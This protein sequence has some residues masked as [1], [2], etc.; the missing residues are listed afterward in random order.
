MITVARDG[1]RFDV[2]YNDTIVL[3]QKT[4]FMPISNVSNSNFSGITSGS[5]G[6]VGQLALANVYNYRLSSQDVVLKYREFSDT[7]GRP[8]INSTANPVAL[9]DTAG[10]NPGFL[11]GLTLSSFIPS[12]SALTLCPAGGCFSPPT[13]RPASPLYEWSTSYA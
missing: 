3:S 9:A 5:S 10:L 2:Y 11:S 1:R 12:A 13:I 4:M 7:R 6:L 8:Y